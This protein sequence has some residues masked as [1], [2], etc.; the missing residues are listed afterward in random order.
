M[1]KMAGMSKSNPKNLENTLRHRAKEDEN[2]ELIDAGHARFIPKPQGAQTNDM[3]DT[4]GP[5]PQDDGKPE[6]I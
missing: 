3:F 6:E 5:E 4:S 2:W 1:I